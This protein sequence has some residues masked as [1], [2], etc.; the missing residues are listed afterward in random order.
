MRAAIFFHQ[1]KI[2]ND[3]ATHHTMENT[4]EQPPTPLHE[5]YEHD[6]FEEEDAT[7]W[8]EVW[9][10]HGVIAPCEIKKGQFVNLTFSTYGLSN[11]M[12]LIDPCMYQVTPLEMAWQL[13]G[14]M[15]RYAVGKGYT[16]KA[17]LTY[18]L[19]RCGVCIARPFQ[20]KY[21]YDLHTDPNG[22]TILVSAEEG[23]VFTLHEASKDCTLQITLLARVSDFPSALDDENCTIVQIGAF[24][25]SLD[26]SH[27]TVKSSVYAASSA[28]DMSELILG[29][30]IS[31]V[32]QHGLV[33]HLATQAYLMSPGHLLS[34][35]V[36]DTMYENATTLSLTNISIWVPRL[37]ERDAI[38]LLDRILPP[39]LLVFVDPKSK[40]LATKSKSF[41][42]N[43]LKG[44]KTDTNVESE[45]ECVIGDLEVH[46]ASKSDASGEPSLQLVGK[47]LVFGIHNGQVLVPGTLQRI[48]L[49]SPDDEDDVYDLV[50]KRVDL[51]PYLP[52]MRLV[53]QMEWEFVRTYDIEMLSRVPL[54]DIPTKY[55]HTVSLGWQV[56]APTC[57][58]KEQEL[59]LDAQP[60][61]LLDGYGKVIPGT[62]FDQI[63][64]HWMHSNT[65]GDSNAPF[66]HIH[67]DD[68]PQELELQE[69]SCRAIGIRPQNDV[70]GAICS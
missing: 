5:G 65:L 4:L 33:G 28:M 3:V 43:W 46:V 67:A 47:Y 23:V 13:P 44:S 40:A 36:M 24:D 8:P 54:K 35:A 63:K 10:E 7:V 16:A 25:I 60:P 50:A 20:S 15:Q 61:V 52:S 41:G 11:D 45:P 39:E 51:T 38:R 21:V 29:K 32:H 70:L 2:G 49:V 9:Y 62:S 64:Q 42:L 66:H 6:E 12:P 14:F 57:P 18:S 37:F 27:E 17:F 1:I 34:P 59:V 48:A 58:S 68:P 26:A 30:A 19:W 55:I 53:V 22:A 31:K 56:V 69:K